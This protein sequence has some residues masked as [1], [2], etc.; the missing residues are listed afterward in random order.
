MESKKLD[1]SIF[2]EIKELGR[3]FVVYL[4]GY[5]IV[6]SFE[7]YISHMFGYSIQS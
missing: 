3:L 7:S 6:H 4:S 5:L 1:Q 2:R